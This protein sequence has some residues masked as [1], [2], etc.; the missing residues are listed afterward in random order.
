M[1]T[2]GCGGAGR[3]GGGF[4]TE[5]LIARPWTD[6]EADLARIFDTYSRPEV[7][8]WL[9]N[10]RPME[11]L[12]EAA[13]AVRRW[14]AVSTA[15]PHLGVWALQRRDD[16]TVVGTVLVKLLPNTDGSPPG[17]LE[18][19]WHLHPDAWG[20][21]YATE[22]ARVAVGRA[23][24]AGVPGIFAVVRP[25]NEPSMAVCRRLGMRSIGLTSRWYDTE[26]EGFYRPR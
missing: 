17:D 12:D 7:T 3:E 18:V 20:H 24:S 9:G 25:G 22:A 16:A 4:E 8:R 1:T 14:A 10:P 19:G 13:A 26:L 15:D 6:D 2:S 5:R 21:G 23:F 11:T